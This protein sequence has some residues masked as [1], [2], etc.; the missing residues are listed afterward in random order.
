MT[1]GEAGIA[2]ATI[3][4]IGKDPNAMKALG[5]YH[6][7]RVAEGSATPLTLED[8]L[9]VDPSMKRPGDMERARAEMDMFEN[10][11]PTENMAAV[12]A[13]KFRRLLQP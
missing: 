2:F 1:A 7:Q 5:D 9:P 12:L 3:A 13:A 8:F 6:R 11:A 4:E 10:G